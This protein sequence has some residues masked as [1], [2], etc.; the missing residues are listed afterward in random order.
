MLKWLLVFCL[1]WA[2]T[3][4]AE[5]P[6]QTPIDR[7]ALVTR[8]NPHF[9]RPDPH[10]PVMLGNGNLGFTADI[11]G[12]QTFPEQ[13]SNLAPLLTMAQ[14][15]FHTFPNP[16]GYKETDGQ[17]RIEAPGRGPQAFDYM[18]SF[19]DLKTHPAYGWLRDNPHRFSLGR[20]A[21]AL[22]G[23]DGKRAT[24]ADL[25][26]TD[27]TLD[28]WTGVLTSRFV[29]E[30]EPVEV[31]T[32]VHPTR[33][34]VLVNIFSKAVATG[35]IAIDVRY[36]GVAANVNP[37][38]SDWVRDDLHKTQV[39]KTAPGRMLLKR[40]LDN[41][42]YY[43]GLLAPGATIRKTGA[44]SVRVVAQK[45]DR[46]TVLVSFERTQAAA[47]N[48]Q[49]YAQAVTAVAD[50]WRQYWKTGGV[51][52]F[53]GST[54][55]RAVELERRVVLSQYLQ[56]INGAGELPP[57]EEG[58]FSNSW[59]GKFHLEM[60]PWHSG[61]FATW[62]RPEKLERSLGWYVTR[63]PKAK[64]AAARH[65]VKGA[66]WP[67]MSGPEAR[68]SPSPIGP[69]IM[70]QQPHPIY[71]AELAWRANPEKKTLRA[72]GELVDQSAQ[73][74]ATWPLWD[75]AGKRYVLGPPIIPV[76]ENY[77]PMTTQ[78]PAFELE[79]VRFG[80]QT[81]QKWRERQ[82]LPRNADWDTVIAKI[83]PLTVRDGLYLPA[84]TSPEFWRNAFSPA[85]RRHAA[86]P[87]CQN[88]DHPSFLMAYGLIGSDRVDADT[89]R[90]T[91][92]A[93]EGNW[94]LR[95]TWG[96]DFPMIAM[97]AARLGEPEDALDWLFI[98]LKNNRWGSTGMTPRVH[99]DT[100]GDSMLPD[101][102]KAVGPDGPGYRRA[103]E[104]Y[105]P[106][107]G[108]LLLAVGMMAA[109]WDGSTGPAPGFPREGWR[110]RVENIQPLP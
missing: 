41:T 89:M 10:A 84:E 57:Q 32:R 25:S 102:A 62:G 48:P 47:A 39:L 58:L 64:A 43:S 30:G 19:D 94:D 52:D 82:G 110:V 22:T 7:Q 86:A 13:Y 5:A 95:Q 87:Q 91:L 107:N 88:K 17:R 104:T 105:F 59:S 85:C 51:I 100:A 99:L 3:A 70:W 37:D 78:N 21:L 76:Q 18:A 42:V 27:Q 68:N 44:H 106:S 1:G 28:M 93:A 56:A 23:R 36:P 67:K 33:D 71:L 63:L 12:L 2:V 65:G 79:Y 73:L 14:W 11:T 24:F 20:I 6:P 16:Q 31:Q 8:H 98:D 38:P 26:A 74:L 77:D 81:A 97:T 9:T 108:S 69:F 45:G 103:A 46:L 50:N 53:S 34:M 80:L 29:F 4:H 60:H 15:A 90:R 61:H 35:R 72:Y 109:G 66:W 92:R 54:D 40:Q 96:W 75:E 101:V 49:D 55:P 83:A